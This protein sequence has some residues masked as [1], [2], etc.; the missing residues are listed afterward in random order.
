MY[1]ELI[2]EKDCRVTDKARSCFFTG[3]RDIPESER[4]P[5]GERLTGTLE[6]LVREGTDTFCAGG[7]IGFDM[8]AAQRVLKLKESV[9]GIKLVLFLPCRDQASAWTHDEREKYDTILAH[10][11][12]IYYV[13]ERYFRGCMYLRNRCLAQ[14]GSTCVCYLKKNSGGTYYTVRYASGRGARIINLADG[15]AD[16]QMGFSDSVFLT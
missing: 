5:L 9:S 7:A 13:S 16:E 12:G 11:D 14:N 1:G 15:S 8:L 6:R 2:T 4:Q 10:A 3:H